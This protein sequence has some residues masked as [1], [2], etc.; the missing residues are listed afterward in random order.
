MDL[1]LKLIKDNW[2]NILEK[3]VNEYNISD[4][5][6]KNW[7][8]PLTPVK[9]EDDKLYFY[10]ENKEYL[11]VLYTKYQLILKTIIS[12]DFFPC[13]IEFTSENYKYN[14]N[15]KNIN[16]NLISKYTFENF[17]V[18][19]NNNLAFSSAYSV[20][21][22]PGHEYNPLFI[23]GGP[24]LGKTHIMNAIAHKVLE[25]YPEKRV[26]FIPSESFTNEVIESIRSGNKIAK[27]F[28]EK[29]R[30]NVDVL[31]IDDIQFL[32][33]KDKTQE[34]FFHTFNSLYS[35]NKQ[36]VI[37]SDKSPSELKGLE[38]RLISRFHSGLTVDIQAPNYE[39]RMAILKLFQE[40]FET[41]FSNEILNYIASNITTSIRHLEGALN[42]LKAHTSVNNNSPNSISLIDAKY[43]LK[44]Y[45][46]PNLNKEISIDLIIDTVAE[47][48]KVDSKSVRGSSKKKEI[49]KPRHISIYLCL[50][51]TDLTQT[52]IG[53]AFGG[54]DHSTISNARD[55][56]TQEINRSKS[57]ENDINTIIKKINPHI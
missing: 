27:E 11:D 49:V 9:Y 50:Q 56:I 6:I 28:R 19:D 3:L 13:D 24:G 30:N 52:E 41:N 20:A 32:I 44:N 17:I 37:S 47:H 31:L 4:I 25:L 51:L 15:N 12:E 43:F 21:K 1:K 14:N 10:F 38:D 2:N 46:D 23:Y 53:Q 45:I 18:G 5:Q 34:E 42:T 55:K 16:N 7:L 26:L 29:Y 57:L 35:A 48:F 36:I 8:S 54:R 22:N 33:G 40:K 39:T